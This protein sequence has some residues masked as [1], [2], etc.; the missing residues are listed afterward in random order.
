MNFFQAAH[1]GSL[2]HP[3]CL[4][5]VFPSD[6]HEVRVDR[7]D[8]TSWDALPGS[9]NHREAFIS[10][11]GNRPLV[12]T[13]R[14][15]ASE[16]PEKSAQD[17]HNQDAPHLPSLQRTSPVRR[18]Y[19]EASTGWLGGL[20]RNCLTLLS[21]MPPKRHVPNFVFVVIHHIEEWRGCAGQHGEHQ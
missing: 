6:G 19:S 14:L 18:S 13:C 10:T 8:D 21:G 1:S 5:C 3:V 12:I 17:P 16:H 4:S 9:D 7:R 15:P 2:R 20:I 11:G